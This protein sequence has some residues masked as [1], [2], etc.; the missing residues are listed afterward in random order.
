VKVHRKAKRRRK[1]RTEDRLDSLE[2]YFPGFNQ[3]FEKYFPGF[4]MHFHEKRTTTRVQYHV[5]FVR[6]QTQ[7][8]RRNTGKYRNWSSILR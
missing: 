4:N 3:I 1:A 7:I 2:K 8:F 5:F 6:N